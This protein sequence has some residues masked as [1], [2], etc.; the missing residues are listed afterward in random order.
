M[1]YWNQ[2]GRSIKIN[3]I[4]V[5]PKQMLYWNEG[6]ETDLTQDLGRTETNVVLKLFTD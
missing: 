5:E 1:L 3:V 2:R 4:R 6:Q